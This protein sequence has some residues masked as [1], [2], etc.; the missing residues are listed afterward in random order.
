MNYSPD[1]ISRYKEIKLFSEIDIRQDALNQI[2]HLLREFEDDLAHHGLFLAAVHRH[3]C[4]S[5]GRVLTWKRHGCSLNA[6]VQRHHQE[7]TPVSWCLSHDFEFFSYE[8]FFNLPETLKRQPPLSLVKKA[9]SRLA[10]NGITGYGLTAVPS[11]LIDEESTNDASIFHERTK[12]G[13]TT[14]SRLNDGSVERAQVTVWRVNG[15]LTPVVS[16]VAADGC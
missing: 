9:L 7:M 5:E 10:S 16:C 6:T 3:H 15:G 14:L 1:G 12:A 8:Y 4:L 2:A 11:L 13:I